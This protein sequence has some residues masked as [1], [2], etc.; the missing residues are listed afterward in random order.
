MCG[1]GF[2]YGLGSGGG[3]CGCVSDGWYLLSFIGACVRRKL[4]VGGFVAPSVTGTWIQLDLAAPSVGGAVGRIV[5][6]GGIVYGTV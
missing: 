5:S 1:H 2:C 6:P 4:A 3:K